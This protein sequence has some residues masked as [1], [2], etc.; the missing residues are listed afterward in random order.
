[1]PT[2]SS[3]R[4]IWHAYSYYDPGMVPKLSVAF[5]SETDLED[6]LMEELAE[7][8]HQLMHGSQVAPDAAGALRTSYR[9]TV[10]EPV[11]RNALRRINP[12][13]P[14]RVLAEAAA[15]MLDSGPSTELVQENLRLHRL[16]VEGIKTSFMEDGEERH[17]HICLIDWDDRH[18]DWRAINQFDVVG[19][20]LSRSRRS[21]ET[22]HCPQHVADRVR[23]ALHAYALCRQAHEGS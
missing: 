14:E 1:M 4:R 12:G 2:A 6:F 15:R 22:G 18:N 23:R 8:D 5:T 11:L 20:P 16:M 7:L 9:Q 19:Q 3:D 21:I 13:L 17:A 10:L